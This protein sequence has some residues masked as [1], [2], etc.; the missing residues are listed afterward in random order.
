M[1]YDEC[2]VSDLISDISMGPFG[3]N[4][5]TDNYR[6]SGIPYLNGSN[7]RSF[8]LSEDAFHYVDVEKADSLR[9]AVAHRGDVIVTH[10]GTLGQISYIP[11]NSKYDRYVTGNSQFR[12]TCNERILPEYLVYFFHSPEG[13]N[14]LL[15]NSSQVG[16]PSLARPTSTFQQLKVNVPDLV[17]QH[18]VCSLLDSFQQKTDTSR[19]INDNLLEQIFAI[20]DAWF[21]KAPQSGGDCPSKWDYVTLD[22]I[23]ALISR[24]IAPKYVEKSDQLVINQKC[25][26]AHSL[27]T[28][29]A[30]SHMPKVQ[31]EKW[32][33]LGDVLINS[34]G[35]G[36]L[37]RTVQV[38]FEPHN[39]TVDSHV[40]IV[41]PAQKMYTFYIGTWIMTHER[42]IESL[43]TGSTGQTE[44]PRD[45]VKALMLPLPP[46][47]ILEQYN[48]L[49][50]PMTNIITA[51]QNE[52]MRLDS[53]RDALLPR[54]MSGEID[55]SSISI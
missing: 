21:M 1:K 32:L 9:K 30:R 18:Q 26:R 6:E 31:S 52:I 51:N 43:H 22:D 28:S 50:A 11:Q 40:T 17:T 38:W 39:L 44:L 34:T 53:I 16:V 41:R 36:T 48:A 19:S 13:R 10:R 8:E 42:E 4:I 24:G 12:L 27:D 7:V 54:L 14:R 2:L 47:D 25:I 23:T 46:T 33:Q 15:S 49:V 55:V 45:R 3:S 20:F 5:K 29:I 35:E 37:G